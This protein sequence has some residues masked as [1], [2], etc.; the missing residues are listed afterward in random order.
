MILT[1]LH[2]LYIVMVVII[3]GIMLMK[4]DIV[5]PCIIGIFA[6]GYLYS[7]NAV[8]AIQSI[9]N[10]IIYSGS[11]FWGIIVIISLVVAMSK[12]LQEIGSDVLIMSP[13]KKVMINPSMAFWAVG[14]TMMI[15]SWLVWPSPAVPLVGAVLL[16]A[17][18]ATGLPIL[19][20]AVAMNLFGHGVALSSDFFIQ[21][22]PT[23]TASGA[24]IEAAEVISASVPIWFAMSAVTI[25]VAFFMMRKDLKRNPTLFQPVAMN[26]AVEVKKMKSTKF[27]SFL[28]P[29]AFLIDIAAMLKYDLA[30][31]DATALV[32]GTA[33]LIMLITVLTSFP[34]KVGFDKIVDYIK[35]GFK[36]GITVFAPVI[37]IAGFFF[38]GNEGGAIAVFGEGAPGILNDISISLS[39]SI[40]MN[41]LTTILTQT[42]VAI[43]TGLDGSGFSGLP[44]VGTLAYTFSNIIDI[45]M[46]GLAALGQV[47]TVWV[48]GGT[49]IPWAVIPVAAICNV[50]PQELARKNLI[51]VLCGIAAAII[52]ALFIL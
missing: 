5:I 37:F 50:S 39:Q 40:Q 35:E 27:I 22:A 33:I 28:T 15:I 29:I 7:G 52:V 42:T 36:F 44:I 1:S 34:I 14:L 24:G 26:E 8:F 30:G 12:G 9:F 4:K 25:A 48:D 18:V 17:A 23:I 43:I 31:G 45:N 41:K 47:I 13:I 3:L 10:A 46:A 19:Y 11:E 32:G 51:P 21:G 6:M 20:V 2:Y 38:I 49:I 16:P